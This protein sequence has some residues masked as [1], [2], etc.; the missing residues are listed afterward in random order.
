MGT[1]VGVSPLAIVAVLIIGFA[2]GILSGS[3]VS[4]VPSHHAGVRAFGATPIEAVGSTLPAICLAHCRRMALQPRRSRRW[5][6]ALPS[7]L[8]GS[9]FAIAGAELSDHV[10]AH[11]LMVFTA[12]LLPTRVF[13]T[14]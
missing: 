13:A 9:G 12:V 6:V 2:S 11:Y 1:L 4:A 8:L 3:S 14:C 7:G 10:N 5:H